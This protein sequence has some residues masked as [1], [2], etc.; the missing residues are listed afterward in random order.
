MARRPGARPAHPR[1]GRD[2]DGLGDPKHAHPWTPL[3]GA[4]GLRA[5]PHPRAGHAGPIGQA[6]VLARACALCRSTGRTP[7]CGSANVDSRER[8]EIPAPIEVGDHLGSSQLVQGDP[9]AARRSKRAARPVRDLQGALPLPAPGLK[10]GQDGAQVGHRYTRMGRS[11]STANTT[12]PPRTSVKYTRSVATSRL[13]A[14]RKSSCWK[15][16]VWSAMSA[17]AYGVDPVGVRTAE[18]FGDA[19]CV[20]RRALLAANPV[21][22]DRRQAAS[23]QQGTKVVELG[24]R[25]AI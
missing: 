10:P 5:R 22:E 1:L 25:E 15:G 17:I 23:E 7:S 20:G 9:V 3:G 19:V 2:G 11:P 12:R 18:E 13:G 24:E 8:L 14:Y 16:A 6:A 21:L 4:A